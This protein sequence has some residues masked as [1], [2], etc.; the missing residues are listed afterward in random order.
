MICRKGSVSGNTIK[1]I[2][3]TNYYHEKSGGVKANY[4]KL[5]QAAD[6]YKRRICLIVPHET[7]RVEKIGE[8]G[9]IYFVAAKPAPIFDKRY[10]LMTPFHYLQNDTPIRKILLDEKPDMI[11]IYDNYSLTLL[12]GIIQKG[13]LK[14]L[15]R[16]MLVYFTGERFDTIFKS[17]V[18]DGRFG[19]WFARRLM[20]NYNLL[21]FDYFIANSPFVAE[22]LF[23]AFK[24]E[25]N[26]HRSE[27]FFEK[28]HRFF[29]ASED[30]FDERVAICPRGV[31][32]EQFSPTKR[33]KEFQIEMRRNAGI[34]ENS[35]VLFSSTRISPEKNIR[36]LPEMMEVLAKDEEKDYRLLVA[37]A[38][39][40]AEWLKNETERRFPK[41]IVLVGH[42]DKETLANYY[43]NTDV[44]VHPNPR[45]P[46][47]NV[48]LEAMASGAAVLVPN[49][50]GILSYANQ[51]NA[52]TVAPTGADF[53]AA[54]KEI[55]GNEAIRQQKTAKAIETAQNNTKE[56][57]V[58]NLLETYDRM[59]EEFIRKKNA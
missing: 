5:L 21:L 54:V 49:A 18:F 27:W 33:S 8:Y 35:T 28:C 51:E 12:A 16:P 47:G 9:K 32:T 42:L 2:H 7:E 26:P 39:P 4:D 30:S 41:K 17:F 36:L 11:E 29:K 31:D 52:W 44:F 14:E 22:E 34:P 57:A 10:R 3:I 53:A 20:G 38:G 59:Y 24:K 58:K 48:A 15:G 55:I 43:A 37:G 46:F 56:N 23:E 25:H 50:G 6:T 40:K 13:Y 19:T 1:S 45:E